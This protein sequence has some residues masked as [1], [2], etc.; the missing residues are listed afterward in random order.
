LSRLTAPAPKC[1]IWS[2][3]TR[4]HQVLEKLDHHVV[5]GEVA[6]EEDRRYDAPD[7]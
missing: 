4:D 1:T 6:M 7:R 5:I 3:S 2:Q